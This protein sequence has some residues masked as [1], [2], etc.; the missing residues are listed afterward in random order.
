MQTNLLH[1]VDFISQNAVENVSNYQVCRYRNVINGVLAYVATGIDKLA[2]V[3]LV[4]LLRHKPDE[5]RPARHF[6][7]KIDF[8]LSFFF[9]DSP[10]KKVKSIIQENYA[11]LPCAF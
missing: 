11:S 8:V 2:Q 9:L 6:A 1:S 4:I 7:K 10:C 3:D 5:M